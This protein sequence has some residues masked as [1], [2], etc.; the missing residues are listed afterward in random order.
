LVCIGT[1]GAEIVS[2]CYADYEVDSDDEL[3]ISSLFKPLSNNNNNTNIRCNNRS[4]NTNSKSSISNNDNLISLSCFEKMISILERE[5][6]VS[7][8]FLPSRIN[9]EE[10]RMKSLNS[11]QATNNTVDNIKEYINSGDIT[12]LMD[13]FIPNNPNEFIHKTNTEELTLLA[14]LYHKTVQQLSTIMNAVEIPVN[15]LNSKEILGVYRAEEAV[16]QSA[17]NYFNKLSQCNN[18]NHNKNK[19]R[20]DDEVKQTRDWETYYGTTRKSLETDK[21][22]FPYYSVNKLKLLVSLERSYEVLVSLIRY[23][24]DCKTNGDND[25]KNITNLSNIEIP[26]NNVDIDIELTET[27]IYI[28]DC[29]YDYWLVK[30]S[31]RRISLLR[32]FHNFVMSNWCHQPYV[33]PPLFDDNNTENLSLAHNKLIKLRKDLDRGI[34]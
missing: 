12:K 33:L 7:K 6:E 2:S 25:N 22:L 15:K 20:D 30:R 14:S 24:N 21:V 13:D 18:N 28:I 5:M 10:L 8:K 3:F 11:L 1:I 34:F 31:Q 4:N 9:T 27:E 17:L 32:C 16:V 29:V 23:D 19:N 26:N